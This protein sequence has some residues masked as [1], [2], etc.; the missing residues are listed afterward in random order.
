[1]ERIHLRNTILNTVGETIFGFKYYLIGSC[2]VLTVLLRD[3]GASQQMIGAIWGIE[4]TS[5]LIPQLAGIYVFHSRHKRKT[6][7][8]LYHIFLMLPALLLMGLLT[9]RANS[10][11]AAAYRWSML[12]LHTYFFLAVGVVVAAWTDFL[13]E[14]FPTAIR[15]TAMGVAMLASS[16]AG[17]AGGLTAGYMIRTFPAPTVFGV[18]YVTAWALATGAMFL[19]FP[20]DDRTLRNTPDVPPPSLRELTRHFRQSLADRNFLAF[21]IARIL[22]TLGFCVIPFIALTY[23]APEKGGLSKSAVVCCGAAL[24]LGLAAGSVVMGRVGDRHGHRIGV[25]VG[26]SMQV[27]TL[28]VMLL[29]PGVGGCLMAFAC[30][31]ISN[32]CGYVSHYN[33]IFETCPHSHRMAHISVGNLLIGVPMGLAAVFGGRVADVWGRPVLFCICLAFSLAAFAWCAL[34]VKDPRTLPA[35]PNAA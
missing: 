27:L 23:M 24:T 22:A 6:Q 33:M 19:W 34:T 29:V 10:M 31:G 12:G 26:I 15:G 11:S 13:A 17:A 3:Y 18:L 20:V 2:T 21:V 30:A 7:M 8:I 1:M 5:A 28:L 9:F 16:L 32:A 35:H 4:T 25:L 14:L